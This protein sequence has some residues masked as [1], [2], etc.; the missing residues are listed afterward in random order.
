MSADLARLL[1]I[2]GQ[3]IIGLALILVVWMLG[4][5]P[6]QPAVGHGALR[7]GWFVVALFGVT[8]VVLAA[9]RLAAAL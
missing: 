8:V 1:G 9:I 7:A 6:S 2:I 3:L 4:R 5:S